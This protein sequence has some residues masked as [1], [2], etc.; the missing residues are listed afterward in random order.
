MFA[1][2]LPTSE[3]F[4]GY[5][6]AMRPMMTDGIWAVSFCN[7]WIAQSTCA[8]IMGMSATVR[9]SSRGPGISDPHMEKG[10]EARKCRRCTPG[11]AMTASR[12]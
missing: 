8:I 6:A 11:A 12:A 2:R 9:V 5:P 10:T 3:A 4:C 7:E 1:G